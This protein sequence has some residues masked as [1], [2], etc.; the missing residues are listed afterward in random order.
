MAWKDDPK[1]RAVLADVD[2]APIDDTLRATLKL[3]GKVSTNVVTAE[4]MRAVLAAGVTR[5]QIEEALDV[6]YAFN[7][8]TRLADTFQFFVGPRAHFDSGAKFLLS[9]GYK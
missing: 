7:I 8:I 6:C 5:R 2:S 4:D 1:V 3:I 9:R